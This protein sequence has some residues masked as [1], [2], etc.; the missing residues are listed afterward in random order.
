MAEK[1]DLSKKGLTF[2]T[3]AFDHR[4]YTADGAFSQSFNDKI[5]LDF[6]VDRIVYPTKIVFDLDKDDNFIE[7]GKFST[8]AKITTERN[9]QH[10]LTINLKTAI[11]LKETLEEAINDL[12]NMEEKE[13]ESN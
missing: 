6:Y 12:I 1:E 5:I 13:N 3:R 9:I 8:F 7:P 2:F 10:S 4:T 11:E